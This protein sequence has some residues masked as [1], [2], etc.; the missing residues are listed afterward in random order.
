MGRVDLQLAGKREQLVVNRGVER[1]S[2]P[3]LLA[4][5]V[6]ASD[7]A[8]EECIPSQD[9]PRL[10]A[11]PQIGDK[12]RDALRRVPGGMQDPNE[13]VPQLEHL[14]I[15]EW[16]EREGHISGAVQMIDRTGRGGERAAAGSV[17]GV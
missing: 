10:G 15:P 8:Y 12:Q 2:V 3:L 7:G 11:A 16:L 5:Q 9:E 14:P 6:G 4:R 17:V 1:R 13:R